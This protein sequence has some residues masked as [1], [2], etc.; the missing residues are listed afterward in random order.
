M[1]TNATDEMIPEIP[2]EL[3][4]YWQERSDLVAPPNVIHDGGVE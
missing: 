3:I 2:D 1:L 4:E